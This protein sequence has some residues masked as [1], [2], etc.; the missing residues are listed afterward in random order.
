MISTENDGLKIALSQAESTGLID[1]PSSEHIDPEKFQEHYRGI[2]YQ[3]KN[4]QIPPLTAIAQIPEVERVYRRPTLERIFQDLY[5]TSEASVA[6]IPQSGGDW[7]AEIGGYDRPL[8]NRFKTCLENKPGFNSSAIESLDRSTD[9]ILGCCGDPRSPEELKKGLVIGY[10][11]SGKTAN[12]TGVIAK[13]IDAGYRL[14]IVMTGIHNNLRRQT[15]LRLENELGLTESGI[16]QADTDTVLL[17]GSQLAGGDYAPRFPNRILEK[18]NGVFVIKKNVNI[19]RQLIDW[20]PPN[21]DGPALIIDDEADQASINTNP[22]LREEA[23]PTETNTLIRMLLKSFFKNRTYV[24]YTATPYANV[25][26]NPADQSDLFPEDF[27]ISLPKPKGYT[28]VSDFFGVGSPAARCIET[29]SEQDAESLTKSLL[30]EPNIEFSFLQH[31]ADEGKRF[32]EGIVS[33]HILNASAFR[34]KNGQKAP[35]SMLVHISKLT[36][37]QETIKYQVVEVLQELKALWRF[38]R[39][40]T[41]NLMRADWEARL[42]LMKTK[43]YA[44]SFDEIIPFVDELLSPYGTE[45]LSLNQ[46]SEDE[47]DYSQTPGLSA[48]VI[49]GDKLSRGLTLEG[50]LT[51]VFLRSSNSPKADTLSQMGR[52]FGYREDYLDLITIITSDSLAS[53]FGTVSELEE[54]LR[55]EIRV[56]Q[57]SIRPADFAPRVLHK[58][59]LLPTAP[60]KMKHAKPTTTSYSGVRIQSVAF[61]GSEEIRSDTRGDESALSVIRHNLA[62]T[63]E[64]I[65]E[66]S[67][68]LPHGSVS[69]A[70]VGTKVQTLALSHFFSHYRLSDKSRQFRGKMLEIYLNYMAKH[71]DESFHNWNLAIVGRSEDPILGSENLGGFTVGR[72]ERNPDKNLSHSP[73]IGTLTNRL[74]KYDDETGDEVLD[75]TNDQFVKLRSFFKQGNSATEAA[76]LT[77]TKG[78]ILIYPISPHTKS[79]EVSLGQRLFGDSHVSDTIV[80]ISLVFPFVDDFGL[81]K[82]WQVEGR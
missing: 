4:L 14:V 43:N 82:Y 18:V 1:P 62:A 9:L 10:V 2:L 17:T 23:S 54:N 8:W 55:E 65:S 72:L 12:Y 38:D 51:S 66:C 20:L 80:G 58:M 47:L 27:V 21:F 35:V 3:I 48:I 71:Q 37:F 26:V 81:E 61:A 44:F 73:S 39:L 63:H 40:N 36:Y 64:L 53:D 24:G 45:V 46:E 19:L 57:S 30:R 34:K 69:N 42:G 50:L 6:K 49:G 33:R 70:F 56:Y 13:A 22:S 5:G 28:G 60:N 31:E 74:A 7:L 75:F 11:Q 52:F 68:L 15:Q 32:L 77:R 67:N 78:L 59:A 79:E 25:F 29:L 76:R 16:G 41:E